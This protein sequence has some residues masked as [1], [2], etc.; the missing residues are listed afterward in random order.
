MEAQLLGLNEIP[1]RPIIDL[2]A[3]R[4]ELGDQPAQ[5]EILLPD[6]FH[7]PSVMLAPDRLRLVPTH[8]PRRHA[9]A[10]PE[11]PNPGDRRADPN[12]ELRRCIA[13]RQTALLNR[14]NHA[15]PKV[16]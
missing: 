16:Y 5:G 7:Q 2:E 6:P 1:H 14:R 4:R 10:R 8:L 13:P 3:A 15:V 12:A 9:T 11:A